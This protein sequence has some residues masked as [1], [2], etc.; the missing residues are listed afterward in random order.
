MTIDFNNGACVPVSSI[1]I[2]SSCGQKL[3]GDNSLAALARQERSND[4]NLVFVDADLVEILMSIERLDNTQI[5]IL[6]RYQDGIAQITNVLDRSHNVASVHVIAHGSSGDILLGN[7]QLNLDTIGRYQDD[8]QHWQHDLAP[9]A[10]IL[11]YGCNVGAG[12]AGREFLLQLSELSGA[13]I[14]ASAN[15]TGNAKLGGDWKLE[16]TTGS[17]EAT[18]FAIPDY[19]GILP[20]YNG[21]EYQFTSDPLSWEQAQAEAQSLGGNLVTINDAAE[22]VWLK[23]IFSSDNLLWIGLADRIEEGDFQWANGDSTTYRNWADGEPNNYTDDGAMSDGEDYAVMNWGTQQQWNDVSGNNIYFGI[24]E[25]DNADTIALEN[26]NYRVNE[27][28]GTA[29]IKVIRTG[30]TNSTASIGY[31]TIDATAKADSDYTAVAGRL[32]FSPGETSRSIVIPIVNDPLIEGTENFN[33]TI[34]NP[35]GNVTLL[36]PRTATITILDDEFLSPLVAFNDFSRIDNLVL[37]GTATQTENSLQLTPNSGNRTGTAFFKR[38]LAIDTNTSFSTQFQF[39]LT[40]GTDGADGFTFIVHNDAKGAKA[41]GEASENLGYSGIENSLAIEFDTYRNPFDSGNN[42]ISL[43]RDGN[44]DRPLA[45]IDAPFDL[46]GGNPLTAW[47]D[48]VSAS[49][50]L[51]VYLS[52]TG[53]KP[54]TAALA[55][56][57]DL[58]T[59]IGSQAYLGFSAATGEFSNTQ[60]IQNWS[61]ASNSYLLPAP[62]VFAEIRQQTTVTNL[63]QPTAIEWTP[64]GSKLFIAEKGGAIKVVVNGLTLPNPFIDLSA[65]VNSP[66]DRGLLDIAIHPDFFNGSPYVYA[67]YTYDP[68]AAAQNIGLAGLDGVGNRASRLTRMTADPDTDY[69]TAI[70]GSE[71]VILGTNS[72]WENFN[73]FVNST[74]DFTQPAAGISEDGTN[75][76]DFLAVDSESHAIGTVKFGLDGALYVSNGDGAS[77]NQVDPRGV[78]VQDIDN[79]SGKVL[80]IDPLTGEGLADNPF[81]NGDPNAN[82]SKVYQSGLRNPFRI[83]IQP[84]SGNV[85]IGDVGW[86]QWEEINTAPAGANFGWPYYEGGDGNNL[87]TEA[88]QDLPQAKDFYNRD[89]QVNAPILGLNHSIEGINALILGDFYTGNTLP[90]QYRGDLFFNDLGQGIVRNITFDP[91]GNIRSIGTFTTGAQNVV[92]IVDAPDGNLYYVNIGNGTIGRWVYG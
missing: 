81:Y 58:A 77:Y 65:A 71:V 79:L 35:I 86:T 3:V 28:D 67:L 72:T 88:Y 44:I 87:K 89:P 25:L 8:F 2:E 49:K 80:R 82:R 63:V 62:P 32:T 12:A 18:T 52:N 74:V 92:Q 30:S 38:P 69:T 66:R 91:D 47:I 24:I 64:D 73:A 33:L 17:I 53:T 54:A 20:I 13:D 29:E 90:T 34:D 1:E 46:N 21:K 43:L 7:S 16:V 84:G 19:Q 48:Y 60:T 55:Y 50:Q 26:S 11:L 85:Y 61:V 56:N 9:D 42:Q 10:D 70:A 45:V 27:S 39:Q 4:R 6:D 78:R 40:G 68:P 5:V 22:E 15:L 57:I 41:I 31:R 37:N 75:L 76:P 51:Q 23:Q 14:A 59:A 36:A 83:T